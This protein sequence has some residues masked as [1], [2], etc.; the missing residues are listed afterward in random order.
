MK[1]VV[2]K[3]TKIKDC[4]KSH[5]LKVFD[6]MDSDEFSILKIEEIGLE[7]PH[8]SHTFRPDFFSLTIVLDADCT[9]EIGHESYHLKS[10]SLLLAKPEIFISNHWLDLKH[11][12]NIT[13]S[14]SFFRK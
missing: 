4:L 2:T 3:I 10:G 11:A 8:Q 13:F 14:S 12:F 9:Y 7:L 6:Y 1:P 5:D